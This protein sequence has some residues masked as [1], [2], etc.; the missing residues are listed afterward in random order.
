LAASPDQ[1]ARVAELHDLM[2]AE[3]KA[4]GDPRALSNGKFFDTYPVA[5]PAARNFY[6]HMLR[7]DKSKQVG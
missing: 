5:A 2:T 7:G 6:E 1:S 3:L 4:Q